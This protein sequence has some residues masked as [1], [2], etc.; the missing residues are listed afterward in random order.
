MRTREWYSWHFPELIKIVNDNI[1]YTRAVRFIKSRDSLTDESKPALTEILGD[2]K[3]ADLV[4]DAAKKSMGYE[5]SDADMKTVTRFADRVVHLAE[6]RASLSNYLHTKM[7]GIAPNLST[8]VGDVVGARLIGHAGSLL[9]LAKYPASTVQILG[10][11][12]ALFRALKSRGNTPK[13]GL[14]FNSSFI[15]RARLKDKGRISRYLANKCVIA[16][17]IDAFSEVHT[18][19][20][21]EHL[22]QQVDDRLQFYDTGL[23]PPKNV[24]VMHLA[25]QELSLATPAPADNPANEGEKKERKK[26]TGEEDMELDAPHTEKKKRRKSEKR[27]HKARKS[28]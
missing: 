23:A 20:F 17:R 16:A 9:S 6:Y 4:I 28:I 5:I 26:S 18:T 10:A 1:L 2:E 12:K 8:L 15:G 27:Q 22:K 25:M 24:D 11:E 19:K 3:Q 7:A 21:G 13:Y 14:I